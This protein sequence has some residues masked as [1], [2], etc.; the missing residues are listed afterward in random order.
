MS[1]DFKQ[2]DLAVVLFSEVGNTGKIVRIVQ[3]SY[4]SDSGYDLIAEAMDEAG[5]NYVY[6]SVG[7]DGEVFEEEDVSMRVPLKSKHL[8]KIEDAAEK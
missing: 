4:T 5:L 6:F 2:G 8:Q 1:H 3:E 7:E